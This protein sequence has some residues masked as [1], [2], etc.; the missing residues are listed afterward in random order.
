MP[1]LYFLGVAL[2][3]SSIAIM[4]SASP[5]L[6]KETHQF[7]FVMVAP[8]PNPTMPRKISGNSSLEIY[9]VR[10]CCGAMGL[11]TNNV[12]ADGLGSSYTY[13]PDGRLATRTWA[14]GI[15]TAYSYDAGGALTNTVYSDSTPAISLSCNM[16]T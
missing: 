9:R 13:T 12:Y 3:Y 15:V 2:P 8:M 14:R 4:S 16:T 11:V 5:V 6:L 7:D 10:A 1:R